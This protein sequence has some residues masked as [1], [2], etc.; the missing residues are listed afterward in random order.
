M[1][2]RKTIL[3]FLKAFLKVGFIG[4]G[5]GSALIPVIEKEVVENKRLIDSDDF[6]KKT[7]IANITPGAIATKLGALANTKFSLI[8]AYAVSLP[9]VI[10]A[11]VLI[12][13]F[14]F[15]GDNAISYINYT[16]VGISTFIILLLIIHGSL[17]SLLMLKPL[18]FT[19]S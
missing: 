3:D 6:T 19:I 7:I 16:S 17:S 14:S 4:F 13:V 8:G 12:A 1:Q 18:C 9:G 11:I 5:G 2:N 10:M 15:L